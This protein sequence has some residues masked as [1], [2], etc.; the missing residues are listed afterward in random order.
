MS[1]LSII[2]PVYN[3]EQYLRQCLDS[4]LLDNQFTGQVICVND[5]STDGSLAI[6]EE[7]ADKYANIEIISQ[8]NAGLSAARNVGLKHATGDYVF[9][10]DSDDWIFP[11]SI[12]KIMLNVDGED[13][14]YFNARVFS[15]EKQRLGGEIAIPN[16]KNMDG[17]AYFAAIY[18]KPRNMPCVCVW[19]G[20]YLRSFL[21]DNHLYNEQ[22]IY[23]EDNYFT[24][25]VLLVAKKVS[26]INEYVYA[27]RIREGSITAHVTERHIKD[28]L[29][30]ASNLYAKYKRYENVADVFYA[31]L[32]GI[33]ISLIES[34]YRHSI[35]VERYWKI[36]DS[37]RMLRGADNSRNRKIAKLTY[38]HPYVAYKYMTDTLPDVC[39]RLINKIL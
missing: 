4:V 21:A 7:Y 3:V 37:R 9:F 11:K 23:H 26:S 12:D 28:L 35:Q 32:C 24:P 30:I 29:F 5:G 6:L 27:Y 34:G 1:V 16:I 39:R 36:A 18:G 25:Q 38:I 20:I 22:G 2:I 31:D 13:A 19:G 33:Y 14:V 8:P 10:I 15:D 17:Q